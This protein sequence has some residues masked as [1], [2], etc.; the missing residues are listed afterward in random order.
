[1]SDYAQFG[2]EQSAAASAKVCEQRAL[3]QSRV[4]EKALVDRAVARLVTKL[5]LRHDEAAERLEQMAQHGGLSL[6]EAAERIQPPPPRDLPRGEAD[7]WIQS[8]LET[9]DDT[10]SYACP[11]TDSVGRV[12]DFRVL[13][14]NSHGRTADGRSREALVGKT[15]LEISPGIA[16]AG[17]LDA[18]ITAY[19]TG[20]PFYQASVEYVEIVN[21][22]PWP[23][24]MNVR[25]ARVLDGLLLNF[26]VLDERDAVIAGWERV[27]R[28]AGVGWA[29]WELVG[30]GVIWTTKVYEMFGRDPTDDP[31]ALEDLPAMAVHEDLPVLVDVLDSL[32]DHQEP[33]DTEFR[34]R[35]RHGVRRLRVIGE[36]LL[37]GDGVPLKIRLLLQDLTP[38]R[39]RER[40][41]TRAHERAVREQE[42]ADEERR[43]TRHL[44]NTLMPPGRRIMHLPGLAVGVCYRPAGELPRFG[45]DCFKTQRI[46]E[47]KVLLAVGDAMGHG[48]TAASNMIRMRS[49]LAGLAYTGAPPHRLAEWLNEL[50]AHTSEE[51]TI[52]GTAVIGCF[53]TTDRT[54][55]WANA[56][57]FAPILLRE[58]DAEPLEGESGPLLGGPEADYALNTTR[59][60]P[61]DT[62]LFYTDGLIE[63]RDRDLDTGIQALVKAVRSCD[64]DDP[65]HLIDCVLNRLVSGTTEDDICILSARVL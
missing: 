22:R 31:I 40:A 37:D 11:I 29:E 63:R 56:G 44:Q 24:V 51:I 1:M 36:P 48:M 6:S 17:L 42:R 4:R 21:D 41:V 39:H 15:L 23:F 26:R 59:L 30:D 9:H 52:T 3:V 57:H 34:V 55:A 58:G 7:E 62:L 5:D 28:L 10:A 65:D 47:D 27:Q 43:I 2:R 46:G 13:A 16:S 45:G 12:I 19:E 20:I 50:T 25:A 64:H 54:F 14:A 49:G 53:D 35:H 60:R 32:I 38:A 8:M 61:G 33:V 18:Y